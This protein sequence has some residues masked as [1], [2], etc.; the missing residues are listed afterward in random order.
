MY[1]LFC[2]SLN[3]TCCLLY[4]LK[5]DLSVLD[6]ASYGIIFH[7]LNY[8]S[9]FSTSDDCFPVIIVTC[10]LSNFE[11][12]NTNFVLYNVTMGQPSVFLHFNVKEPVVK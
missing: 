3:W 12:D 4:G 9:L 5:T 6:K 11:D 10:V 2:L 8:S 1:M 7:F